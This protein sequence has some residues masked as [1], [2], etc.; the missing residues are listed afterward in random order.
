IG[1]AEY[2]KISD[3][4]TVLLKIETGSSDDYFLAFNRKIGANADN[5]MSSDQ[6]TIIEAGKNGADFSQS[7]LVDWLNEAD[8]YV[9]KK[10]LNNEPL[11]VKVNKIDTQ[12]TPGYAEVEVFLGDARA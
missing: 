3:G 8:E 2:D 1:V 5:K 6:V 4:D 7:W 11:T 9:F 12:V 10:F